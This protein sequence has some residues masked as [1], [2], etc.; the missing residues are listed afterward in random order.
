MKFSWL[1]SVSVPTAAA[2]VLSRP[3]RTRALVL[4]G[5]A[6]AD[7]VLHARR[8]GAGGAAAGEGGAAWT[9][10]TLP[11][12]PDIA[13][14]PTASGVGRSAVPPSPSP[15]DQVALARRD[16]AGVSG[17]AARRCRWRWRTGPSSRRRRPGRCPCCAA[18]RSRCGRWRAV[19]AA[20]VGL[21]DDDVGRD[22]GGGGG[23]KG[24]GARGDQRRGDTGEGCPGRT[25]HE[26]S[27][28]GAS[29]PG[30]I[31]ETQVTFRVNS[32]TESTLSP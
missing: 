12:L 20:S 13:I 23:R 2:V 31:P 11:L 26:G 10:A 27:S 28:V 32:P 24:D 25:G 22:G 21:G 16:G 17:S 18:R 19:A 15:P 8:G 30:V 1:S 14:V 7:E 5:G 6:V 9:S 4:V 3:G 29:G